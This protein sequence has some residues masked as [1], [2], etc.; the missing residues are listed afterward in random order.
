L[1]QKAKGYV[2]P[3]AFTHGT[4]EQRIRWFRRG[5]ETGDVTI[6]DELFK[7]RYQDL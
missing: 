3:D 5:F 4:S 2:V 1:Q 7:K 6:M